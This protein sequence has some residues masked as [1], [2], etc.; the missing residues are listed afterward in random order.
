[1]STTD[2]D[3]PLPVLLDTDVYS[4]VYVAPS[5]NDNRQRWLPVLAGRTIAVAVQTA[6]ELRAWPGIRGWGQTKTEALEAQ[7]KALHVFQVTDNVQSSYTELTVWAKKN[8]HGIYQKV[9]TADRWVAATALAYGVEFASNDGIY[10]GIPDLRRL[11]PP[12]PRQP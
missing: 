1:L 4:W 7:L 6:A 11:Q 5:N 3:A 9:H 2:P 8:G 12:L 10:D